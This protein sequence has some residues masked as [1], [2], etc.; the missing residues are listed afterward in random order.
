MA[1]PQQRQW[2][3]VRALYSASCS[4]TCWPSVPAKL[5]WQ[6]A[7]AAQQRAPPV[8]FQRA[9]KGQCA[10]GGYRG[11][12]R[13]GRMCAAAGKAAAVPC[14]PAA[15]SFSRV[16]IQHQRG[17]P[18]LGCQQQHM[19]VPQRCGA[20]RGY[21]QAL[22]PQRHLR[23]WCVA[24]RT[25]QSVSRDQSGLAGRLRHRLPYPARTDLEAFEMKTTHI[26]QPGSGRAASAAAK[27]HTFCGA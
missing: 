1:G 8:L 11:G 4:Y 19:I 26:C 25:P 27:C 23:Q 16:Q 15:C 18:R 22:A 20:R 6:A 12:E 21:R 9:G 5:R 7:I 2:A 3:A 17:L 13:A 10:A 24:Q 14:N